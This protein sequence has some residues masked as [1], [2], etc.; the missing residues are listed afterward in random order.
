MEGTFSNGINQWQPA[1]KAISRAANRE[2]STAS[3]LQ[4]AGWRIIELPW[5]FHLK[6][7]F[8]LISADFPLGPAV[9][10]VD[11]MTLWKQGR[12][13]RMPGAVVLRHNFVVGPLHQ[14]AITGE[15]SQLFFCA[16]CRWRFLLSRSRVVVLDD[17]GAVMSG[18]D[19]DARFDSF[20]RGPCPALESMYGTSTADVAPRSRVV[21]LR[22]PGQ[23]RDSLRLVPKSRGI[24]GPGF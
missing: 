14:S 21:K 6:R 8:T 4:I 5:R 1:P 3:T 19:A 12:P 16:R 18:A 15:E 7:D 17:H 11:R 24:S 9:A 13:P 23:R 22:S 10:S 2:P 20:E